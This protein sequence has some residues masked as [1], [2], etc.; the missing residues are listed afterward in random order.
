MISERGVIG[1]E[2][3]GKCL[4]V[5]I[6]L[7]EKQFDFGK[8]ISITQERLGEYVSKHTGI[9]KNIQSKIGET[10]KQIRMN[11]IYIQEGTGGVYI[12]EYKD[13][14]RLRYDYSTFK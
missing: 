5:S 12:R 1:S 7:I 13:T 6:F 2:L 14:R 4:L 9:Q 3:P 8:S 10:N 11:G